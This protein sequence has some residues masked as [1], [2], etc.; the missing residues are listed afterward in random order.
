MLMDDISKAT[1]ARKVEVDPFFYSLNWAPFA[2]GANVPNPVA[3]QNDSDF[4][5]RYIGLTSYNPAG[6]FTVNP[7]F[8]IS[9]F[10]NGSGRALQDAPM[11][12]QLVTG[13]GQWPFPL[14]EPK[15]LKGGAILTVT[16][17]NLSGVQETRVDV[18]LSGLKIF[19]YSPNTRFT[20]F[21]VQ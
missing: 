3:I 7:D 12:V 20:V 11:H 9:L 17:Q 8:L 21:G 1:Q 5:L 19:Y 2:I 6:T 13:N 16:L 14:P 4:V 18:V 10:D 15:L